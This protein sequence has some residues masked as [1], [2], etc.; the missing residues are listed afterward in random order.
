[1]R[2]LIVTPARA[3]SRHGNRV[4]ALRWSDAGSLIPEVV[5]LGIP[6]PS[7]CAAA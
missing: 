1:M 4:T 3:G 7:A 5:V 2:I 6:A